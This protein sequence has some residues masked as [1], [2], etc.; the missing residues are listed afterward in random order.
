MK[1]LP[2][3]DLILFNRALWWAVCDRISFDGL[4]WS[5]G[6]IVPNVILGY[7]NRELG[8][9]KSEVFMIE[10]IIIQRYVGNNQQCFQS[11]LY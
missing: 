3:I 9:K 7:S 2:F 11:S 5:I 10:E 1:G 8:D 4:Y 6:I